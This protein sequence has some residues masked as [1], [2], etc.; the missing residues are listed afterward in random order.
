MYRQ[1][2]K[3]LGNLNPNGKLNETGYLLLT[4]SEFLLLATKGFLYDMSV[5]TYT[6]DVV[7]SRRLFGRESYRVRVCLHKGSCK[8]LTS[9]N[10]LD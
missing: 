4:F 8:T 10:N 9:Y 1:D 3:V 2:V 6:G 7:V 5:F